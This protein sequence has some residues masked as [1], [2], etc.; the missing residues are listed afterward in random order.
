[1]I[2]YVGC[3]YVRPRL[4]AF[5]DGELPM[6]DQVLVET[7]L[8]WC[9]TCAARLED[10]QIIG[11]SL[12]VA[13]RAHETAAAAPDVPPEGMSRALSAMQ[14]EVL[15]RVDTEYEQSWASAC[16]N[17]SPTCGCGGR[18]SGPRWRWR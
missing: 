8:R 12:R 10:A 6:G 4:D 14:A 16:R 5:V 2:R 17:S 13:A 11:A 3:D 18:P 7:H 1:M 9:H 15:A